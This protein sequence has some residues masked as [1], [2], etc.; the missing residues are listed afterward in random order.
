MKNRILDSLPDPE[1]LEKLYRDDKSAFTEAFQHIAEENDSDLVRFW[2][3]RLEPEMPQPAGSLLKTGLLVALLIAGIVALLSRLPAIFSGIDEDWFY[4]RNLAVI[5]FAGLTAFTLW[6][7]KTRDLKTILM[8]ALPIG[9][10]ALYLNLMRDSTADTSALVFIHAPLFLW[11]F[12]GLAWFTFDFR[13]SD[14]VY[15]FIRYNGELLVMTG[16]ILIAGGILSAMTIS[17]FAL[18]GMDIAEFYMENIALAGAA[19]SPVIASWLIGQFPAVTS[20]IAPLIARV[21]TPVVLI[22]AVVYLIAILISGV[23]ISKNRDFLVMFNLL[24]LAVMA[25]LVFSVTELDRSKVRDLYLLML[26]FLVIVTLVIN[27]IALVAIITRL[28]EGFTPNRTVVLLSN[29]LVFFHLVLVLPGLWSARFR[30]QPLDGVK[31][32]VTGYLPVYFFYTF[33]VIFVLPLLW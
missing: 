18:I 29:I 9:V 2:K 25:I 6:Q 19:A 22:S 3:L 12:F 21:F 7:R 4:F 30:H 28:S 11:C 5:L 10:L 16:L 24:L 15:G 23:S 32:I 27:I 33:I 17:L 13:N 14:K 31:K 20:R 8:I 26:F 1:A